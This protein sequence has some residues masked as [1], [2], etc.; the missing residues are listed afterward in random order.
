MR[1]F[2]QRILSRP[3]IWMANKFSSNPDKQ[4]V[5]KALSA[6][7]LEIETNPGK[8]GLIMNLDA[9]NQRYIVLS[10]QHKGAKNDSDMFALAEKNYLTALDYYYQNN[11]YYINLGDCEELWENTLSAVKKSNTASFGKEK[12]FA[13]ENRF[14]KIFGNH[15]LY[16]DNDP[17]ASLQLQSIYNQKIKIYEGAI[18]QTE[19][20][21]NSLQVFVTHGHQGDLQSDGSWFS[22]WFVANIWEPLQ[23]YLHVNPNTP[24]YNSQLKTLHNTFMYEWSS[25]QQNILLITGHTHQPVFKSLTELEILYNKLNIATQ[26][27]NEAVIKD[28]ESRITVR[29]RK[30]DILPDYSAIKP[31]YFNS[32]CCCFNDGDISGIEIADGKI[33]LIKWEYDEKN[34]SNR[35]VLEEA[36]LEGLITFN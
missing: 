6:L 27:K 21:N 23:S 31:V 3:V 2:L 8:R 9:N 11:F 17:F 10:D 4:K 28:I 25:Q 7:H 34:N 13:T 26:Q 16:W 1:K 20:N 14:C 19:Y 22:K 36:E 35:I 5:F 24:A 29:R 32:G 18:L 33:R 15:D 30:G 12:I